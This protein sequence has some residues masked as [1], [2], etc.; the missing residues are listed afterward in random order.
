MILEQW[1]DMKKRVVSVLGLMMIMF[2]VSSATVFNP[3]DFGA[4]GD[5]ITDDTEAFNK[6]D[7][8]ISKAGGPVEVMIPPGTY[9]VNPLKTPM[10]EMRPGVLRRKCLIELVKDGSRVNCAGSIKIIPGIDYTA[11]MK[12]GQEWYW[13]VV[14]INA[15]ACVVDGLQFSGNGTGTVSGHVAKQPNLRWEGVAGFGPGN[16]EYHFNN[17][18]INCF[19]TGGGGQPIALQNQKQAIISGNTVEDST[20]MGFSRSEN[21][22]VS[23]NV[24]IRSHD[25]PFIANGNCN[26][27]L[28]TGNISRGTS[29]GSGIDVVG[30]SN[31]IVSNN[32][33][34]DSAAWGLLI[35]YSVQQKAG[36]D[37]I[38][39]TGNIFRNNGRSVDTPFNGEVMVGR[40]WGESPEP[41]RNVTVS[42]NNFTING[43]H[44]DF[45]G[46]FVSIGYGAAGVRIL[47]NV[48][49]GAPNVNRCVIGIN[50]PISELAVAG[51]LWVGEGKVK[52]NNPA[53]SVIV[54]RDNSGFEG[55]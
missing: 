24:S 28:I 36:C 46:N 29:N 35:G 44:G 32:I 1:R 7:R 55:N 5:G 14:L 11:G 8:A 47:N 3:V 37:N 15:N 27:I 18:V 39:V 13:A 17:K 16:N 51:N 45:K 21:S 40:P 54:S 26:N 20:G 38:L 31:V 6:L 9:M 48:V 12:D 52:I 30:C 41:I 10:R 22:V 42:N 43:S 33:I 4:K 2:S 53:G 23:N 25:A 50:Q 34:E 49:S 19:I